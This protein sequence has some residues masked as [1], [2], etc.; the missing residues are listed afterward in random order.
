MEQRTEY[1]TDQAL[2]LNAFSAMVA[3]T[4]SRLSLARDLQPMAYR[5]ARDYNTVLGYPDT[6]SIE[7][8]WAMYRRGSIASTIV[9]L[10]AE[11][12]WKRPPAVSENDHHDTTFVQAWNGLVKRR[13]VWSLLARADKLSGI[14]QYGAILIGVR[15]GKPMAEP[16]K[17]GSLSSFKD[18]LYYRP[19]SELRAE[20]S[21]FDERIASRR[22]GKPETYRLRL[23][24]SQD[25][26][27]IGGS[28][29]VHWSRVIH[30]A[31]GKL[32]SEV[33]GTPRL[34]KIFNV[35]MDLIFKIVGCTAETFWLSARKG[36]IIRPQKDYDLDVNDAAAMRAIQ[37]EVEKYVHDTAR[38]LRMTG[39]EAQEIGS[40]EVPDPTGAFTNSIGLI[41]AATKIPQRK[42]LGTAGG[43]LSAAQED[44][45]QWFGVVSDRQVQYAEPEVLRAFID[46]HI[47]AGVLPKPSA[48]YDIGQ[49][50]D[51]GQRHWPSLFELTDVE[52][53]DISNKT[54]SAASALRD[55]F[56]G[57][58]PLTEEE[59]RRVLGFPEEKPD[60]SIPQ[61]GNNMAA[62]AV[63]IA[64]E[65][66]TS[67]YITADQLAE[68]TI[69]VL[70]E[71]TV[72]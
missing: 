50:G 46:W 8:Y 18:I 2:A 21:T 43:D 13:R 24:D 3:Q 67:G 51:D 45:R 16:L 28:Q 44:T 1:T 62:N 11:D 9:D 66:F 15:D 60:R 4:F 53:A 72:Q 7:Q 39:M 34:R 5:G 41:A 36:L 63:R 55:P 48:G 57:K 56:T 59:E 68:Y 70:A 42:L 6:I 20:I 33:F 69:A 35:A 65:N 19:L 38:I 32:D 40:M 58:T 47:A 25:G 61:V 31:D 54:A 23:R 17:P 12:T 52:E 71:N 14:G 30:L 64:L 22:F 27:D 49:L 26:R 37:N 10:P 29:L